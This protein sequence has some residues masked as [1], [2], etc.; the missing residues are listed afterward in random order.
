MSTLGRPCGSPQADLSNE[1]MVHLLVRNL[2]GT[3][4]VEAEKDIKRCIYCNWWKKVSKYM[5]LLHHQ[6]DHP[7]V[8]RHQRASSFKAV[9][10]RNCMQFYSKLVSS[11]VKLQ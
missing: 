7:I 11:V 10:I 5:Y 6:P 4:R 3:S 2:K 9:H 1:G 8:Y